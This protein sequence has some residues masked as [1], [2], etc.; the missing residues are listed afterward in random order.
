MLAELLGAPGT[1]A[2]PPPASEV[3]ESA[4]NAQKSPVWQRGAPEG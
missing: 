4:S 1:A 3:V 2:E